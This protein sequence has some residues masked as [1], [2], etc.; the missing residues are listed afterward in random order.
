MAHKSVRTPRV[1]VEGQ[2]RVNL[3]PPQNDRESSEHPVEEVPNRTVQVAL[4]RA[5]D[6][7]DWLEE[8]ENEDSD[9]ELGMERV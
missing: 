4:V 5:D 3:V 2:P 9:A 1:A 7:N 8:Y 6:G